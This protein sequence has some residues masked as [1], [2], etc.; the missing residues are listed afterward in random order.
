M[1]ITLTDT[2]EKEWLLGKY[3]YNIKL[4]SLK[5]FSQKLGYGDDFMGVLFK[6]ELEDDPYMT[7]TELGIDINRV[8]DNQ[9]LLTADYPAT[10]SDDKNAQEMI[11]MH[12]DEFYGYLVEI[13]N[14][15]IAET[16]SDKAEYEQLLSEVKT[17]LG[18]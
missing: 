14:E 18:L 7:Q 3:S 10:I 17:A 1:Y 4:G 16:P 15:R 13:V 2:K 6:N 12:F 5:C 8:D 11:F 9:I